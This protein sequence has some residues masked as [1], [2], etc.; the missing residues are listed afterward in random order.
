MAEP[1]FDNSS[2]LFISTAESALVRCLK[3]MATLDS[4]DSSHVDQLRSHPGWVAG[5]ELR[6]LCVYR[7]AHDNQNSN[8]LFRLR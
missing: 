1:E 4:Q 3:S 7:L 2:R 5:M 8:F 6:L